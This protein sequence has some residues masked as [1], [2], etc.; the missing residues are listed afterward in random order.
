MFSGNIFEGT[1]NIDIVKPSM[2]KKITAFKTTVKMFYSLEI[3]HLLE[4]ANHRINCT[5]QGQ[6]P[7]NTTADCGGVGAGVGGGGVGGVCGDFPTDSQW[8]I[9]SLND[10][11]QWN[12]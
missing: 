5:D 4:C 9:D 2:K 7:L 6:W 10:V 1:F 3:C 8:R 11:V 12:I